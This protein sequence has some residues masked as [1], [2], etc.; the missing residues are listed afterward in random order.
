MIQDIIVRNDP[1]DFGW[2]Q[3]YRWVDYNSYIKL[4]NGTR[5][6]HKLFNK[7]RISIHTYNATTYLESLSLNILTVIF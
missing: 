5:S 6:I 2:N 4:D 3:N 7:C 1:N